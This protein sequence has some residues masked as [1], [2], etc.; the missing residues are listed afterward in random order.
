M[1]LADRMLF[2]LAKLLKL[3]V[4]RTVGKTAGRT[5]CGTAMIDKKTAAELEPVQIQ[6][7]R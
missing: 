4:D 6:L 7:C 5:V 3:S 2:M 1:K